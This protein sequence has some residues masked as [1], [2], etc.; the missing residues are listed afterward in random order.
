M[1]LIA[2][3]VMS[4]LQVKAVEAAAGHLVLN[5]VPGRFGKSAIIPDERCPPDERARRD[6]SLAHCADHVRWHAHRLVPG[7]ILVIT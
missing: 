4:G 2:G 5:L 7:R 6:R 1:R 3:G